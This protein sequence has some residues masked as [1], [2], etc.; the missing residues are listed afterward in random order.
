MVTVGLDRP[1]VLTDVLP[2]LEL[3]DSTEKVEETTTGR[4]RDLDGRNQ[5]CVDHNKGRGGVR[6][7]KGQSCCERRG[8]GPRIP[9]T[10]GKTDFSSNHGKMSSRTTHS[11]DLSRGSPWT[12]RVGIASQ[13]P[14]EGGRESPRKSLT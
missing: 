10:H 1:L 2:D 7:E 13:L 3:R 8:V 4:T 11:C 14:V 12:R 9:L 5:G 6:E